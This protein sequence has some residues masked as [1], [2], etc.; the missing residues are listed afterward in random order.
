M[1]DLLQIWRLDSGD[2]ATVAEAVL[3][4]WERRAAAAAAEEPQRTPPPRPRFMHSNLKD[5]DM[6]LDVCRCLS[7]VSELCQASAELRFLEHCNTLV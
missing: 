4:V 1:F 6:V 3:G 5:V 2:Y 7:A